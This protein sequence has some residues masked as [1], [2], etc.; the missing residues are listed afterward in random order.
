MDYHFGFL[1]LDKP[2]GIT[3]HDCVKRLRTIFD[4]KRIGHGGTLDPSV[5]GVL[6]IAI[7]NAT[8]LIPYLKT[9]KTYIGTI[10]LGKRTDTDD[11]E[12]IVLEEKEKPQLKESLLNEFLESFKGSI[13]QRPPNFSSVHIKGERAYKKARRGEIFDIPM[14]SV[15]IQ[16]IKLLNWNNST[17]MLDL[18]I[19]CS[20]GTY[21]RALARDLG[22]KIGCG[23]VLAKLR[24]VEAL[25]FNE[26]Q[27]V[28]MEK[29][30]K[31][32]FSKN[33]SIINPIFPLSHLSRIE[34]TKEDDEKYWRTGRKFGVKKEDFIEPKFIDQDDIELFQK[35]V[36]VLD[37][38]RNIVG[39]GELE[40]QLI[41]KPKVV[42]NAIG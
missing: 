24:R 17:G 30:E 20:S 37:K 23:G 16:K 26:N 27:A 11:M 9:S 29:I 15:T 14:K 31:N 38:K 10:E 32:S 41:I 13:M 19:R 25:G 4:T 6:P 5:T 34:L 7:G 36:L 22:E 1:V 40:E 8:R 28:Y 18:Y 12:G 2:A 21:I 33:K 42:F 39:I 3:S 35:H